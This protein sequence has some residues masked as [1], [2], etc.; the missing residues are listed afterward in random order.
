MLTIP[1]INWVAAIGANRSK[2]RAFSQAKY[3]AQTGNDWQCSPTP[4]TAFS[5]PRRVRADDP[6]DANVPIATPCSNN[7]CRP[8]STVGLAQNAGSALHP[9]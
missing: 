3:G 8:I 5:P 4:A 1:I 2:L 7:G 9:R 6:N